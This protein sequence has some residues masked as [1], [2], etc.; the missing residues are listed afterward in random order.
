M[1][2]RL[3][4]CFALALACPAAHGAASIATGG[5]HSL[6]I[7]AD[8]TVRAW[9]DDVN[10]RPQPPQTG[11]W[12]NPQESGRGFFIEWQ[13]GAANVAGYMYDAAGNPTWYLSI[14]PTPDPLQFSG[15]WWT[16]AGGQSMG[17]PYRPA[18]QTSQSFA[19]PGE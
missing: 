16:Y 14:Y 18:T 19:G 11:W 17:G 6:A 12:W 10:C 9:G 15:N 4:A 8:G 1:S 3:L 7:A 2:R 13:N 5:F